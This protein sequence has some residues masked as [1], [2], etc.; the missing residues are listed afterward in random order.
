[1]NHRQHILLNP[2]PVNIRPKVRKTLLSPDLCHREPEFSELLE[3]THGNLLSV[4]GIEKDFTAVILTGSGTLALET[5][6]SSCVSQ[7]EKILII[8]N[9]VYGQRISEIADRHGLQKIELKY[10]YNERPKAE[11]VRKALQKDTSIRVVAMVHHE[12]STGMLNPLNEI[13][14]CV[15]AENRSFLI[16][17]ISSLGGEPFDFEA[18]GASFI[19]GTSGKCLHAFPGLSFVL[20]RKNELARIRN[21]K[22]RSLYLDINHYL[23][24]EVPFTPSVPLFYAF[25][26][27]LKELK[28]E[29]LERRIKIYEERSRLI[30]KTLKKSG[31]K[32]LLPE[33]FSSQC[34][35]ALFLPEGLSY[36]TLHDALKE[37][38]F[39]IYAGQSRFK[40]KIFRISN[41]G[42]YPLSIIK[43]FCR[44]LE[45]VLAHEKTPVAVD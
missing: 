2:G 17:A 30:H 27:A 29:G 19:A 22:P 21:I 3:E 28:R 16:D 9:G 31:V 25:N 36:K 43:R 4:F 10:A 18:S 7:E 8:N 14:A 33:G 38:G 39:V 44:I 1:M 23:Q 5:A 6:V 12:T 20:V 41:M 42:D 34:L 37:K 11:D 32:F 15:R 45:K 26:A 40:D 13:G 35:V 24:N